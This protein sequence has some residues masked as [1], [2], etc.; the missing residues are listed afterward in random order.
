MKRP[1]IEQ[2]VLEAAERYREEQQRYYEQQFYLAA[3]QGVCANE[4]AKHDTADQAALYAFETANEMMKLISEKER[5]RAKV[6]NPNV[7]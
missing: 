6:S 2:A 1:K 4:N 7:N 3:L 5:H